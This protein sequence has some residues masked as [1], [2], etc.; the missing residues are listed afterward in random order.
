M[1]PKTYELLGVEVR[2][3]SEEVERM[4]FEAMQ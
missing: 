2:L 1:Q 4:H 3:E